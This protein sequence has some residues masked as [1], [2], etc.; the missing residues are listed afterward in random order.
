V[1]PPVTIG[2]TAAWQL[3]EALF[4]NGSTNGFLEYRLIRDGKIV[5]QYFCPLGTGGWGW[6]EV[7]RHA[8]C[9]DVFFGVAARVREDGTKEAIEAVTAVWIDLDDEN[10]AV[11]LALFGV[12]PSFVVSSGSTGHLHAYWV[13]SEPISPGEAEQINR[14]LATELGGDA[15]SVDASRMM[16]LPGTYNFKTAPPVK[17]T[18]VE[19]NGR[20]HDA[21]EIWAALGRRSDPDP[22]PVS[23]PADDSPQPS[24]P[25]AF[26]LE[27]LEAVAPRGD[28]W[29]ALC[30]AHDDHLPSL[31]IAEGEDG[32]C[33]LKCF[34]ECETKD[35]VAALGLQLG[36]LFVA[37]SQ[38]GRPTVAGELVAIAERHG[39]KLFHG[40]NGQAFATIPV[41]DHHEIAAVGSRAFRRWLRRH[42]HREQNR[43]AN[44][45]AVADAV[46]LLAAKAE[47]DGPERET[48]VRIA[49]F[50]DGVVVDLADEAWRAVRVGPN[51]V[52]MLAEAP[53]P[54]IRGAATKPLPE[55]VAGG[56]LDELREFVNLADETGWRLLVAYLVA[57][58][59]GQGPFVILILQGEKG[60]GKSVTARVIRLLIDPAKPALRGGSPDDRELLIAAQTSYVVAFDNLS[61]LTTRMSDS[62]CRLSTGAGFGTR[63]LYT[64]DEEVVFDAMRPVLLN[65]I[66]DIASRPDLLSRAIVL[67][68][69]VLDEEETEPEADFDERFNEARP[70][71]LGVLLDLAATVIAL[72]PEVELE[73]SPRM[74]DFARIGVA[75]ERAVDWPEGSFLAAYRGQQ[76]GAYGAALDADPI[77]AVLLKFMEQPAQ[78][79]GWEGTATELLAKLTD[80][81]PEE[82]THRRNWPATAAVLGKRLKE[83][84]PALRPVGLDVEYAASGRGSA[85]QRRLHIYWGGRDGDGGDGGDG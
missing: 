76:S 73:R 85:K 42:Y 47:F 46:D 14:A 55:P 6:S 2:N 54:F 79:D 58:L 23:S 44:A 53:V 40:P 3:L 31:S 50:A 9:A 64:D 51:R 26:V 59:I 27:R 65:G 18:L 43:V 72:L 48:F 77:G 36:D 39:A 35:V 83:L 80:L 5:N 70:R 75:V 37:G 57:A 32:R 4:G 66:A 56:S 69:P 10:A 28:G 63:R 12:P 82:V 15:A 67:E 8:H 30:P 1:R 49:P 60:S 34:A 11:K 71:I 13:L 62:L 21:D 24:P 52:E 74:A 61:G 68:L 78:L 81:A 38:A 22:P 84:L 25:V 7:R 20:R 41:G 19:A 45:Q 33:L 17:A 16:R 29:I